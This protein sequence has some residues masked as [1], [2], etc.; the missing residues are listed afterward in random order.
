MP[1]RRE[2]DERDLDRLLMALTDRQ[3]ANLYGMTE[4]EVYRLR[5]SRQPKPPRSRPSRRKDDRSD[6]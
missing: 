6:N 2:I 5:V 3:I 4:Q 1:E